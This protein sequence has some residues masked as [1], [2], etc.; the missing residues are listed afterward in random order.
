MAYTTNQSLLYAIKQ[1]NDVSWIEF[2]ET[3]RPL[4]LFCGKQ[5]LTSEEADDLVQ[6][7]MLKFFNAQK[8]FT[9]DSS[10]G[11]F[12]NYLGKIIQ[13]EIINILQKRQLEQNYDLIAEHNDESFDEMWTKQWHDHL[14]EQAVK[15]LKKRVSV[16]T[17]QAFDR[18]AIQG[19]PPQ[20]V[21]DF[22]NLEIS[23][24]YKAKLRCTNIL[25][26]I[27]D[28]LQSNE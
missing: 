9:Y 5:K 1:G 3:Y 14:M 18:Y 21:A 19:I 11:L 2:Y 25:R 8:N 22:L 6:N 7:V 17:F 28:T 23:K 27:I 15:E 24:V 4:I 16:A 10:K 13:N 26:D 12:R 20:K